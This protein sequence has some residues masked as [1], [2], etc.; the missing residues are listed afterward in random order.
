MAL[1]QV[2][3]CTHVRKSLDKKLEADRQVRSEVY[4]LFCWILPNH[5]PEG[6]LC[7]YQLCRSTFPSRAHQHGGFQSITKLH[8]GWVDK[9]T[10]GITAFQYQ[11]II[12]LITSEFEHFTVSLKATSISFPVNYFSYLSSPFD[13]RL[14]I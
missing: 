6:S 1:Y 12:S 8:I 2:C 14:S 5:S 11:C 4:F 10:G 9:L 7:S 13:N 3:G